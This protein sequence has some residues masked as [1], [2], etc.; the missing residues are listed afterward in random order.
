MYVLDNT[1]IL[2][3]C[4]LEVGNTVL[5]VRRR[6]SKL[7]CQF[8]ATGTNTYSRYCI[9]QMMV[10]STVIQMVEQILFRLFTQMQLT[11]N[12]TINTDFS[13]RQTKSSAFNKRN[14]DNLM[15]RN[16]ATSFKMEAGRIIKSAII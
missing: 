8:I 2:S 10:L 1:E 6:T 5:Q 13:F 11:G 9:L 12:V 3:Y 14:S 4:K 16:N 15:R 7:W